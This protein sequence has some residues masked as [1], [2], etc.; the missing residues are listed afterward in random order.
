MTHIPKVFISYSHDTPAHA[1][2]V[3]EIADQLRAHG[4]DATI[5]MFHPNPPEGWPRWMEKQIEVSDFVL[6]V[7]TERYFRRCSGE[8]EPGKG[9]A[10]E[11]ILISKELDNLPHFNNKF[12]PIVLESTDKQWIIQRMS[13]YT[14]YTIDQLS[15]EVNC[16]YQDLFRRIANQPKTPARVLGAIPQLGTAT[17]QTNAA[18]NPI[19]SESQPSIQQAVDPMNP[20]ELVRKLA[21]LPES[22]FEEIV[23]ILDVR[24]FIPN[25]AAPLTSSIELVRYAKATNRYDELVAIYQRPMNWVLNSEEKELIQKSLEQLTQSQR[26]EVAKKFGE[27]HWKAGGSNYQQS[28]SL[29]DLAGQ[30]E[31]RW[32]RLLKAIAEVTSPKRKRFKISCS[33][34]IVSICTV[35]TFAIHEYSPSRFLFGFSSVR[36]SL[37]DGGVISQCGSNLQNAHVPFLI[38]V[39]SLGGKAIPQTGQIQLEV[40]EHL[41]IV[42]VILH[43]PG[44]VEVYSEPDGSSKVLVSAKPGIDSEFFLDVCVI[45]KKQTNGDDLKDF[46]KSD[47]PG[48]RVWLDGNEIKRDDDE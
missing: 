15:L 18:A 14:S 3:W 37:T 27:K 35:M 25:G 39:R 8:E 28:R 21:S 38:K 31:E 42:R 17:T 10:W 26:E 40:P 33:L 11:S 5:D 19:E 12:I 2:R 43:H 1:S 29:I 20:Q 13:S 22:M 36:F 48:L 30:T 7:F 23:F 46:A 4:I 16:G 9:V 24:A 32:K 6:L 47:Y 45:A 41:L 44:P 34:V